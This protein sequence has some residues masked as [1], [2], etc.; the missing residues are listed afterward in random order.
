MKN[1]IFMFLL[2]LSTV[3]SFVIFPVAPIQAEGYKQCEFTHEEF[4][5]DTG[6]ILVEAQIFSFSIVGVHED[7]RHPEGHLIYVTGDSMWGNRVYYEGYTPGNKKCRID[8]VST[9][10]YDK[11]VP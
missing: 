8:G 7:C 3:F 4:D 5:P 2:L 10:Y 11:E 6:E 9:T 1:K